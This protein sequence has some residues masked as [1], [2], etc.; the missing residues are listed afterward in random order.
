MP[1]ALRGGLPTIIPGVIRARIRAGDPVMTRGALSLF[2]V[3]RVIKVPCVLKLGSITDPFTGE[4]ETLASTELKKSLR[5]LGIKPFVLKLKDTL[6]LSTAAGPNYPVSMMGILLDLQAWKDSPSLRVVLRDYILKHQNGMDFLRMLAH[7]MERLPNLVSEKA[8]VLGR[9]SIKQEAAG[10]ARVFAITDSIT[11]MVLKP[12][13]DELFR[14]LRS[15]PMDGTFN[16]A[17]PLQRLVDMYH[18]GILKGATFYSYDL[19]SATDRLPSR[20]QESIL[21]ILG[22]PAFGTL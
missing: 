9:L 4:S 15:L 7:D 3:Y 18:S 19:S 14:Q 2:A 5:D 6:T 16:Q 12:L 8:I 10:K 22:G 11:Q 21:N 17:K 1:I 20:L 13:H